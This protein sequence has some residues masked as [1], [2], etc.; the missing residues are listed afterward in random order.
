MSGKHKLLYEQSF[1]NTDQIVVTHNLN[2]EYLNVQLV[3]NGVVRADLIEKIEPVT[4]N[5][6][7]LTL[8]S[9]QTGVVLAIAFDFIN[10]NIP[11]TEERINLI[12]LQGTA[13]TLDNLTALVD[14]TVDDDELDNYEPGSKWINIIEGR[15]FTL[16]DATAGAALWID[17]SGTAPQP[18]RDSPKERFLGTLFD[19][20]NSAGATSGQVQYSRLWL[21][22]G[23][24]LDRMR[25]FVDSGGTVARNV[26][27]G[28]YDQ[29]DPEDI[30][31][32]PNNLIKST[33]A[34]STAADNGTF[35]TLMF[36]GG[37]ITIPSTGYY[38]LATIQDSAS[39]QLA[40][41]D[42]MRANY[43]PVFRESSTGTTLPATAGSLSN[44]VSSVIYIAIVEV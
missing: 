14:P 11:T 44:P 7:E 15:T 34:S 12:N 23:L 26:R 3:I 37:S 2:Q 21:A 41:S 33:V 30:D 1:I 29:V 6:F 39:L 16:T 42:V 22:G 8:T 24:E 25:C 38:W 18:S 35:K 4:L 43:M 9:I 36:T 20:P 19:Y 5:E 17:E 10:V 27:F 31:G 28:L 32:I 13:L 40:V